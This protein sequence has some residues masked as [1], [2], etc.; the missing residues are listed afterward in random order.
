[1]WTARKE[2]SA[3]LGSIYEANAQTTH[4]FPQSYALQ[5]SKTSL[6]IG[7]GLKTED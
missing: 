3:S 4:N 6:H 2:K 1:M 5:T 7:V